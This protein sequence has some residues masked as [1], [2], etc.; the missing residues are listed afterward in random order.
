MSLISII[1]AANSD[2]WEDRDNTYRALI[3]VPGASGDSVHVSEEGNIIKITARASN[4]GINYN[5]I[6]PKIGNMGAI[7]VIYDC[8]LVVLTVPKLAPVQSRTLFG[9]NNANAAPVCDPVG[10]V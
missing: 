1:Q 10:N 8:G 7:N 3:P 5:R 6:I 9:V 4:Y 2:V